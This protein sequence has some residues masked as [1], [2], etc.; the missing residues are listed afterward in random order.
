MRAKV[1]VLAIL[2]MFSG[3]ICGCVVSDWDRER[4]EQERLKWG[5]EERMAQIKAGRMNEQD[6][7]RFA[8]IVADEVVERLKQ[9]EK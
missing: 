7:A 6:R 2:L 8:E 9:Q 3:L 1:L 5:H 4:W